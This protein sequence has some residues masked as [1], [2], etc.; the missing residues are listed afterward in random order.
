MM[1]LDR[2]PSDLGHRIE[3]NYNKRKYN[4]LLSPFLKFFSVILKS[5]IHT[6]LM[7]IERAFVR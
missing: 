4:N 6:V 3:I 2:N 1:N 7:S 5:I